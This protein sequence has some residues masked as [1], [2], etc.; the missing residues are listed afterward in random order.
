MCQVFQY[1]DSPLPCLRYSILPSVH[2]PGLRSAA[3][4]R[5]V[6]LYKL[7]EILFM[8]GLYILTHL[9][10]QSISFISV[11]T[12]GYLLEYYFILLLN[13]TQCCS[14]L[15][16]FVAQIVAGLTIGIS[17]SSFC[18]PLTSPYQWGGC[19]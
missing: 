1:K 17:S 9:F 4:L 16:Y 13:I 7:F 10:V 15:L 3:L 11:W 19:F 12:Q 6:Y 14:I 2:S 18:T 8:G 5:T